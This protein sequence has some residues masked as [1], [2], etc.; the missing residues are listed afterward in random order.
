MNRLLKS[1]ALAGAILASLAAGPS[2]AAWN[3]IVSLGTAGQ[4]FAEG[5]S[6]GGAANQSITGTTS[7]TV[8]ANILI[9]ANMMGENARVLVRTYWNFTGTAGTKTTK[10]YLNSAATAGGTAYL[11]AAGAAGDLSAF[12]ETVIVA[13]GATNSQ[14]GGLSTG[15][16]G[17]STA[18][19]LPTGSIDTTANSYI[20]ISVTNASAA[21]TSTLVG[22]QVEILR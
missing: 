21:D 2:F 1:L 6:K 8:L 19:A 14:T 5:V 11:S 13:K 16:W 22:Y 15:T 10:V 17:R 7:E 20:V 9:P 12:Y 4:G 18:A 3:G